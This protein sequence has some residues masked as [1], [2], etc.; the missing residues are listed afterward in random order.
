[1]KK[2]EL[3]DLLEQVDD[4]YIE[5]AF[6]G[7]LIESRAVE[8]RAGE[9][10]FSPLKIF[11]PIAAC[12]AL[13]IGAGIVVSNLTDLTTIPGESVTIN[14]SLQPVI[15][16]ETEE[17]FIEQ[18]K[19]LISRGNAL[20]LQSEVTWQT[21]RLD[22]DFD[23]EEELLIYP[24]IDGKTVSGVGVRV[25][26]TGKLGADDPDEVGIEYFGSFGAD[27]DSLDLNDIRTDE[28][29]GA[30]ERHYYCFL[31]SGMDG[32]YG[33]VRFIAYNKEIGAVSG[34]DNLTLVMDGGEDSALAEGTYENGSYIGT[35][36]VFFKRI[37][38]FPDD[39]AAIFCEFTKTEVIK[40]G[41]D[42]LTR[43]GKPELE[44]KLTF[45]MW[46]AGEYD[47]NR[48]G[49]KELLISLYNFSNMKGVFVYNKDCEYI[50]SFE[51]EN[52]LCDPELLYVTVSGGERFWYYL[53]VEVAAE[54]NSNGSNSIQLVGES[55]NKLIVQNNT[56]TT[57]RL[58]H[59]DVV[60]HDDGSFE[61]V[62]RIGDQEVSADEYN[63]QQ[64]PALGM[65]SQSFDLTDPDEWKYSDFFEDSALTGT[66][67]GLDDLR[68]F[69][70]ETEPTD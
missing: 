23:G 32:T 17:D 68:E 63:K 4:K 50:G 61:F 52:G 25:F 45:G 9:S 37:R 1:M 11:A 53:G 8:V 12:L 66:T 19:Y 24:Q 70:G 40:C 27:D 30:G 51:T 7:G 28:R 46:H 48:D 43:N 62:Y 16:F 35:E 5:E 15:S 21:R 10:H 59:M 31:H 6:F 67:T 38:E 29:D 2:E 56:F 41:K 18:G 22:L 36:Q 14:N 26:R 69:P 44:E 49:D 33:G 65:A 13:A 57:E 54:R 20:I 55:V 3:F 60:T 64:P 34:E 42:A 58:M 47:I 39:V